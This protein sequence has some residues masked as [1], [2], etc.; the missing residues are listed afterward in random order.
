MKGAH[1]LIESVH[2]YIV[3]KSIKG[4][5]NQQHRDVCVCVCVQNNK[6]SRYYINTPKACLLYKNLVL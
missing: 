5:I 3:Y 6:N 4:G 2:V 1:N